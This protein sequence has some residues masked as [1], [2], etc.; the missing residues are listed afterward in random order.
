MEDNIENSQYKTAQYYGEKRGEYP[1]TEFLPGKD[2][3]HGGRVGALLEKLAEQ[4]KVVWD[5]KQEAYQLNEN[6]Q[7]LKWLDAGT[8]TAMTACLVRKEYGDL[9]FILSSDITDTGLNLA[10]ERNKSPF[11][12]SDLFKLP[13]KINSLDIVTAYDVL[14]HLRKPTKAIKECLRVIKSGGL[15][16]IVVPNPDSWR[17][18][19]KDYTYST[20]P[21]HIIPAII[22]TGYFRKALEG[23]ECTNIE[24]STRG[25]PETKDYFKKHGRELFGPEKGNHIYVFATKP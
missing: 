7:K 6:E 17:K 5:Q 20:D 14:E 8:G 11:I 9:F 18:G 12:L 1:L 23:L 4:K 24:I 10:N 2:Q 25:F 22:S 3:K 19:R 21:S 13:F 15:L 16:H